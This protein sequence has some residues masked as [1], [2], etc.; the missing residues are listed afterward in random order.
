MRIVVPFFALLVV[1]SAIIFDFQPNSFEYNDPVFVK[2]LSLSSPSTFVPYDYYELPFCPLLRNEHSENTLPYDLRMNVDVKCATLCEITYSKSD[3]WHLIDLVRQQYHPR[4]TIDGLPVLYTY[5]EKYVRTSFPI[6]YIQN[7][8]HETLGLFNH[9]NFLIKYHSP[10]VSEKI[11]HF[12]ITGAHISLESRD[13]SLDCSSSEL[14]D[15][16]FNSN[17]MPVGRPFTLDPRE[18]EGRFEKVRFTYSLKWEVS[19]VSGEKRWDSLRIA[20][21]SAYEEEKERTLHWTGLFTTIFIILLLS[22]FLK[23]VLN[24]TIKNK[25][26]TAITT[27]SFA[28][29]KYDERD[30]LEADEGDMFEVESLTDEL[31]WVV[32]SGDIFRVPSIFPF[33]SVLVGNGIQLLLITFAVSLLGILGLS[34]IDYRAE[35]FYSVLSIFSCMGIVSGVIG[36]L[37]CRVCGQKPSMTQHKDFLHYALGIPFILMIALLT[38]D[39]ILFLEKPSVFSLSKVIQSTICWFFFSSVCVFLGAYLAFNKFNHITLFVQVKSVPREIPRQTWLCG[40]TVSCL[41]GGF[42]LW[43]TSSLEVT[44]ILRSIWTRELYLSFEFLFLNFVLFIVVSAMTGIITTYVAISNENWNWWWR[45]FLT[46]AT[47]SFFLFIQSLS[48]PLVVRSDVILTTFTVY[49]LYS[50]LLC[51]FVGIMAGAIGTLSSFFFL[52]KIYSSRVD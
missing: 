44:V 10:T 51:S 30:T 40:T 25:H 43:L 7:D 52:K 26:V 14:L 28:N 5:D 2:A 46:P 36:G 31:N 27:I 37:M 39:V 6:G 13:R 50:L 41:I 21:G 35:T 24:S 34:W 32:L 45:S 18:R 8:D 38:V 4:L 19:N 33:L 22:V 16:E 1:E 48:H 29:Q 3:V 42:T 20:M 9:M 23:F 17:E 47:V 11:K 49:S 12:Q 15:H